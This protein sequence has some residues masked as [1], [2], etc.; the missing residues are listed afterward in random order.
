MYLNRELDGISLK[1]ERDINNRQKYDYLSICRRWLNFRIYTEPYFWSCRNTNS[2]TDSLSFGVSVF[3]PIIDGILLIPSM[4]IFWSLRKRRSFSHALVFNVC[5]LCHGNM[6][7]RYKN[8][9]KLEYL[10]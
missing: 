7:I 10:K 8:E 5:I 1:T 2:T 6:I 3:Y 4:I 9:Y